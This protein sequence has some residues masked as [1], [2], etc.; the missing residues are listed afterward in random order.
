MRQ[1]ILSDLHSNIEALRACVEHATSQGAKQFVCL[2]DCVGYGAD[3]L[4]TLDLLMSL[5]HLL[6]IRGNHDAALFLDEVPDMPGLRQS[7]DWTCMQLAPKHCELL[8]NA[9]LV[10]TR[11][12]ATY[13]HASAHEP[14]DWE[15]LRRPEQILDCLAAT[16]SQITFIGHVHVPMVFF[17]TANGTLR[18]F[19]PDPGVA[20]PLSRSSRYVVN[21]GSVGQPRDGNNAASYAIY[22][23]DAGEV[24]IHRVPYDFVSAAR[25]ILDAGLNA[26]YAERL[27]EG[28]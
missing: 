28:R 25:K 10:Q 17:Q 26:R 18:E 1:A 4:P 3:P 19:S 13:A 2:G 14:Q 6:L 15:Y 21:V 20:V 9:P 16:P 7:I 24:T 27:V 12:E 23:P 5:P 22:D 8:E 11:G